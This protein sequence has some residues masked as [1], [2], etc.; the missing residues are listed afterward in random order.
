M[1]K[2]RKSKLAEF[3]RKNIIDASKVLFSEQGFVK[4]TVD[5]IAKA[6]D[7]SKAT[8]YVYFKSKDDIYYH[9]VLEYMSILYAEVSQCIKNGDSFRSKYF[10]LCH[11]LVKCQKTYPMYFDAIL[12]KISIDENERRALPVLQQIYELGEQLNSTFYVF[13][14]TAQQRGEISL[15]GNIVATVFVI[16]SSVCSLI[17]LTSNKQDYIKNNLGSSC[18][19]FLE[20]GFTLILKMIITKGDT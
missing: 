20:N 8:I 12:G 5:D 3:N 4:T 1:G 18:E 2:D 13:L 6:A 17:S 7:C 15:N 14:E 16:W 19:D 9:I 10:S 11:A